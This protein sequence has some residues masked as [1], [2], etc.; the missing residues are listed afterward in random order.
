MRPSVRYFSLHAR[1][2]RRVQGRVTRGG[3]NG[4]GVARLSKVAAIDFAGISPS[5]SRCLEHVQMSW[6]SRMQ[7]VPNDARHQF[8]RVG[9]SLCIICA[10]SL[11]KNAFL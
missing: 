6:K 1:V 4:N 2:S 5:Y 10:R 11:D 9:D 8:A 3:C 7:R